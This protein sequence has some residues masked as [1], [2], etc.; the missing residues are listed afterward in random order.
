MLLPLHGGDRLLGVREAIF[1]FFETPTW[2]QLDN[3]KVPPSTP[4]ELK[5]LAIL[6]SASVRPLKSLT[7]SA[8]ARW[9]IWG[10]EVTSQPIVLEAIRNLTS[11]DL[12]FGR[13]PVNERTHIQG[14]GKLI[15]SN[16]VLR[17]L[18]LLFYDWRSIR[19]SQYRCVPL[20]GMFTETPHWPNLYHLALEGLE[21]TSEALQN[22]LKAQCS[23]LRSLSLGH[24]TVEPDQYDPIDD[25]WAVLIPF[26]AHKLQLTKFNF[27]GNLVM[28]DEDTLFIN[29]S[30]KESCFGLEKGEYIGRDNSYRYR[31]TLTKLAK[32]LSQVPVRRVDRWAVG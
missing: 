20:S 22:L 5:N 15:T 7:I 29:V 31:F 2:L 8:P 24:M 17:S 13:P 25:E 12:Q 10:E 21:T 11:I 9:N 30:D 28:S 19:G 4:G 16:T 18:R 14:I 27:T 1:K 3:S 32:G 6:S 23:T 26:L